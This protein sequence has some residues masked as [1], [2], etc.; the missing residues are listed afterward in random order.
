MF[1]E[2]AIYHY[3]KM[4]ALVCDNRLYIKSTDAGKAFLGKGNLAAPYPGASL[5]IVMDDPDDAGRL[6]ELVKI[7]AKALPEP[8][9]KKK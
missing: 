6:C 1:G 2:Y 4:V 9:K 8:K 5:H 7:T 3:D